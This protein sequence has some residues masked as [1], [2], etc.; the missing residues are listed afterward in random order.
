ME[1]RHDNNQWMVLGGL[2]AGAAALYLVRTAILRQDLARTKALFERDE[3]LLTELNR[4]ETADL[5]KTA[6]C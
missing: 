3:K 1:Y 4:N 2:A 6:G 5:L